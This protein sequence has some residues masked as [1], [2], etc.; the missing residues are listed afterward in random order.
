MP[1]IAFWTQFARLLRVEASPEPLTCTLQSPSALLWPTP[2]SSRILR[3]RYGGSGCSAQ[4]DG[5]A[6]AR[7]VPFAATDRWCDIVTTPHCAIANR[8][9]TVYDGCTGLEKCRQPPEVSD[10]SYR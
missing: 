5:E 1:E 3:G 8:P 2:E 9:E 6:F 7:P 4:T 10:D